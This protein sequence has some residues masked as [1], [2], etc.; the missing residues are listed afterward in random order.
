MRLAGD[1][2]AKTLQANSAEREKPWR[3]RTEYADD[4][5]RYF[6]EV[7]GCIPWSKQREI[8]NSVAQHG[9]ATAVAACTGP[10]KTWNAARLVIWF[11]DCHENAVIITTANTWN[12]IRAQLWAEIREGHSESRLPLPGK[13]LMTQWN[14]GPKWFALGISANRPEAIAGFHSKSHLDPDELLEGDNPDDFEVSEEPLEWLRSREVIDSP[15][16]VVIDEASGVADPLWEAFFGLLT[17][18]GSRILAQGN[19]TR[20]SGYFHKIFHP[21][22]DKKGKGANVDWNLLHISAF[23]PPPKIIAHEWIERMRR[24]CQPNPEK[25][26]LW[27][28]R[29][30][31]KFPTTADNKLFPLYLL[32]RASQGTAPNVPTGRHLGVDIA[33]HGGD[34]CVA[35]LVIDGRVRGVVSWTILETHGPNL[36]LTA[37]RIVEIAK[38]WKVEAGNIHIDVTGIGWGVHDSLFDWGW[39]T[40]AVNFGSG[41]IEDWKWILGHSVTL[42]TRRQELHWTA[43]R[44]FQEGW[45]SVPDPSESPK[46]GEIWSELLEIEYAYKGREEFWVESKDEYKKRVGHSPDFSDA[47]LCACSRGNPSNVHFGHL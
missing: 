23:D 25:H 3:A 14:I 21:A 39:T 9:S 24:M 45:L 37:R 30:L 1:A 11:L 40:D 12:Q 8:N 15:V 33:R 10:G 34:K 42:R 17:N 29:V 4:P 35:V 41:P 18:P 20:L 38:R 13:P 43:L 27:M 6:V 16:F 22:P 46:Y 19:P 32:E 44:L 5:N 31:G 2:A 7:L 28:V 26:P 36:V 47:L